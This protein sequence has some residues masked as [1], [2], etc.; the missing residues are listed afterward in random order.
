MDELCVEPEPEFA[1]APPSSETTACTSQ[2]ARSALRVASMVGNCAF[3]SSV[4]G[5][6]GGV[7]PDGTVDAGVASTLASRAGGGAELPES[8]RDRMAG[9]LGDSLEDVRIHTDAGADQLARA[10]AA[11]AF[12]VGTDV[13]FAGGEYRP[14]TGDGDRLIAHELAH[15][16]QQRG[17]TAGGSL[18]VTEPGDALERDADQ[19]ADAVMASAPASAQEPAENGAVARQPTVL[20]R[21]GNVAVRWEAW[22]AAQV[23][24]KAGDLSDSITAG[25]GGVTSAA[26]LGKALAAGQN[27][28][29]SLTLPVNVMSDRDKEKLQQI[30]L[31]RLLN[32]YCDSYVAAHPEVVAAGPAPPAPATPAPVKPT[33]DPATQPPTG[34][35]SADAIDAELMTGA[36]DKIA[37]EVE[38]LWKPGVWPDGHEYIWTED[39]DH[40]KP[41][42]VGATGAIAFSNLKARS[43]TDTP[44][45]GDAAKKLGITLTAPGKLV[46]RQIVG[47]TL[48]KS[49][50]WTTSWFDNL[51]VNIPTAEP[52]PSGPDGSAEV[53]VQSNW[54]WDDNTTV[55]DFRISVDEAGTPKVEDHPN[56]SPDASKLFDWGEAGKHQDIG[57]PGGAAGSSNPA[58]GGYG[59]VSR[60]ARLARAAAGE[61]APLARVVRGQ[62]STPVVAREPVT[63]GT[64][65]AA[66]IMAES[67]QAALA[68]IGAAATAGSTIQSFAAGTTGVAAYNLP[69]NQI[70]DGDARKLRQLASI[71][72]LNKYCEDFLAKHPELNAPSVGP[73]VPPAPAP[74]APQNPTPSA[75]GAPTSAPA[76]TEIDATVMALARSKVTV[77]I[78]GMWKNGHGDGKDYAWGE[79]DT[80]GADETIGITGRISF[81]NLRTRAIEA[82]PTLGDAATKLGVKAELPGKIVIRQIISGTLDG[83]I[84]TSW[85]DDLAIN[86]TPAVVSAGGADGSVQMNIGTNWIWDK[87]TTVWDFVITVKA[88]G[89]PFVEDKPSGT[90]GD[91]SLFEVGDKGGT[92]QSLK[93]TDGKDAAVA[94]P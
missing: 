15:V 6:G 92:H 7:L 67:T 28:V 84:K 58:A 59:G 63:I 11:R 83:T 51:A 24:K 71:L 47:G 30:T 17:A 56:G 33:P 70:S 88:D 44:S 52:R 12:A 21:N 2:G 23:A 25:L 93:P 8:V 80:H 89:T 43:M 19:A 55:W 72:L 76:A 61:G 10:V 18:A 26:S 81:S 38:A 42:T 82:E 73:T 32:K 53:V 40:D 78:D 41:D 13:Y 39:G 45:V 4:S 50:S 34:G 90:P 48:D 57:G 46:V 65:I 9:G 54:L 94:K 35:A 22:K 60:S 62:A 79:D 3:R 37:T 74:P 87:N 75:T 77:Q 69:G 5:L 91:S 86:P 1:P 64:A 66:F 20:A 16:V 49:G 29:Q 27:G 68:V 14:G 31:F 36:K 85:F